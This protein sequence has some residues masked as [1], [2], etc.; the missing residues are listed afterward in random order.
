MKSYKFTIHGNEY[1]VDVIGIEDNIAQIEVNGTKYEIEIQSKIKVSKT[2][3]IVRAASRIAAKPDIDKKE[4]GSSHTL[5]APLPGSITEIKVRTGDI[6]KKGQLLILME[7][8]KMENQILADRA[9]VIE[10]IRV[11]PGQSV[12]QGDVLL[13]I[14]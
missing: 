14:I 3:T 12:L 2:P 7:A 11:Q 9:G 8:M 6:I 5:L 10:N 13:E 4:G 1:G